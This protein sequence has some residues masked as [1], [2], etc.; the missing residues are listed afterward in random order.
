MRLPQTT[1]KLY[2]MLKQINRNWRNF[3]SGCASPCTMQT[4]IASCP[5]PECTTG[6]ST[7]ISGGSE[8][9]KKKN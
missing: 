1:N 6:A 9:Y 5:S 4:S 3:T 2:K 8:K 7:E